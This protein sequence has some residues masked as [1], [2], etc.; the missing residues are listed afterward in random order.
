[1]FFN[2]CKLHF[3]DPWGSIASYPELTAA[4][5]LPLYHLD[6]GCLLRQ[7]LLAQA[8]V[9]KAIPGPGVAWVSR[10]YHQGRLQ[11]S[12]TGPGGHPRSALCP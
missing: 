12:L 4:A 2:I 7:A 1:M 8:R 9:H 3:L 10:L 5:L 11:H 6:M